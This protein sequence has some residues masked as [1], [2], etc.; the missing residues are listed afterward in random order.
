MCSPI[1]NSERVDLV[2]V[3]IDEGDDN[4]KLGA[5]ARK[6]QPTSRLFNVA[7]NHRVHA[8]AAFAKALG[9]EPA[10]PSTV[11]TDDSGLILSAQPGI[12]SLSELR[13]M[14]HQD[15]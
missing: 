7:T 14:L 10:M 2:L 4:S 13:K 11:V 6:W 5:Y 1:L 15:P 3:P 12:P 8:S 9:Q